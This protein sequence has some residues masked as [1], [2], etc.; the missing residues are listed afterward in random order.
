ML[1]LGGQSRCHKR[2]PTIPFPRPVPQSIARDASNPS[3]SG[4][5]FGRPRALRSVAASA[6]SAPAKQRTKLTKYKNCVLLRLRRRS[7]QP[8]PLNCPPPSNSTTK[9]VDSGFCNTAALNCPPPSNRPAKLPTATAKLP[10]AQQ[11]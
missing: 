4:A 6:A 3:W 7:L 8:R 2:L 1:D 11:P 5:A 10:P 9:L